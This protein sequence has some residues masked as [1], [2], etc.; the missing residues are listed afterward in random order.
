MAQLDSKTIVDF[1]ENIA[2]TANQIVVTDD[3]DGTVTLSGPQDIHT[4]ASPTF[5][6]LT[7]SGLTASRL[8]STDGS[9]ALASSNASAFIVASPNEISVIDN[10]DGT[11]TM[12]FDPNTIRFQS[13]VDSTT[14]FQVLDADGGTPVLNVDT[15]NER[16]GLGTDNP[17]ERL[18]I[19]GD[20]RLNGQF[21][22][23]SGATIRGRIDGDSTGPR[24]LGYNSTNFRF[25]PGGGETVRFQSNG[26]VGFSELAPETLLELTHATPY[27]TLHNSTHEDTDGGRESRINFKG[28]QSGGE[29]TTLARIE[30]SHSGTAN[31]EKGKWELYTNDGSDGDSPTL[32][33]TVDSGQNV[34]LHAI[35][36]GATQVGAGAAA[37]ELW[38]TSSHATLPDNV[39]MIGV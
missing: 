25:C 14:F 31:D 20:I 32:A 30:V 12:G 15:T 23:Y 13:S 38:K 3:T 2:G 35:K 7:L 19:E 17:R 28:E 11:V 34:F 27:I 6:G 1:A 21:D 10:G 4:G 8:V 18:H 24:I 5:A 37:N 33:V 22:I 39:I 16:V 29:E 9:T 36:S 26:N